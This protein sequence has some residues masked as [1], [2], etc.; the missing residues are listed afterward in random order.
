MAAGDNE[1]TR[2]RLVAGAAVAAAATAV[3]RPALA[4]AKAGS[5]AG[6]GER[7]VDVAVVGA[8]LSGLTA[9]RNLVRAGKSVVVLEADERVGGRTE[10]RSLG[11]GKVT[12][13]MGEYVGPTQDRILA[14]ARELGVRTFKTYNRGDNV[15]Y[16]NGK[17]STY[18]TTNPIPPVPFAPELAKAV[19]ALDSMAS[20]V[21]VDAPWNAP[22]AREWDS[23]TFETWVEA[24]LPTKGARLLLQAAVNAIWGADARDFSLLFAVWYITAAGNPR[25]PGNLERLIST[26]NGAQERRFV[27]GSQL[28]STKLAKNLG[29]RVVLESPVRMI[30]RTRHGV[31]VDS[32]RLTV[33]AKRV[34]VTIP[35]AM[36]NQI[37]YDPPLPAQRAQ[38]IQRMPAGT[39]IKAEATYRKPFW[40][41]R[42]LTGQVASDTG[43]VRSTFDNSP[44]DG[45]PGVLFGF[46]GGKDARTWWR[47]PRH[48]RRAAVL[49]QFAT[50][51]GERAR[52]PIDYVE[53]NAASEEWIRGCP[54]T[55]WPTG[56]LL[57]YGPAIREPVHRIHWAG[58]ETSTYWV[59]YM[60]GAVRSGERVAKEALAKL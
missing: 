57:N 59:G 16:L 5:G 8:G 42:G 40:R 34:I 28:I 41:D 12:E 37:G 17:R 38:L 4:G 53:D 14:L 33:H 24:N 2:R 11:H 15:L 58:S 32:D 51:F 13:L 7:R 46:I 19:L 48:K 52:D 60:D 39:L 45:S 35:P 54:T 44:P 56:V 10:N 36:T 29:G 18:P 9:A 43:P 20:E 23:Q 22:H 49:D 1:L 30:S 26:A 47:R 27:G 3:P 31:T 55:H 21:P 50:Y 25:H 6:R